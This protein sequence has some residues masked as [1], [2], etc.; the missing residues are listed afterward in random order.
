M[1]VCSSLMV[2]LLLVTGVSAQ[3]SAKDWYAAGQ[4]AVADAKRV[5]PVGDRAK[6]VILFVGDG[7]GVTTVTAARIF[8]G[9]RRG[10]SGEENL[11]SFE[12]FPYS[13]LVKT[14]TVDMQTPD[15]AGTMT[16]MATG[17]KS[18][19]WMLSLDP[20]VSFGDVRAARGGELTTIL[21]LCERAGLATGIVTTT[22]VTHATPA[23]LYAHSPDRTWESD[24]WLSEGA[25]AAGFP[26]IARQLI[27][28]A[29]GDGIDVVFGGGRVAFLPETIVD[30]EYPGFRGSR[31]DGRNLIET[32]MKKAGT[33]Y[34]TDRKGFLAID[35]SKAGRVL[36]LFEP[37][38][39]QFDFDRRAG[40][41]GEPSL[42]EMTG[43]AIDL[44]S[45][46][47]GSGSVG[48]GGGWGNGRGR[49]RGFFLM[50]EAGRIDH[51]HH[52]NN[53][54]R[55]LDDTVALSDAVK[56]A[57]EKTNRRETLILVTADHGHVFTMAGYPGRGNDITGIVKAE[58]EKASPYWAMMN[59]DR[60]GLRYTTLG[61]MNGPGA[62][63][64]LPRDVLD[65]EATCGPD[66]RQESL[67]G[68]ISETHGGQDVA[69]YAD[70]P[71]A[72]LFRGVI[73][74]NV[75]F[76]V[77][78]DALGLADRARGPGTSSD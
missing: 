14:Y 63:G 61:Y 77:M 1:R 59:Q 7:M 75:I 15:S 19:G 38:H 21:D 35:A 53:A 56:V 69:I 74:Q 47:R 58:G 52:I 8:E 70:G 64:K 31:K 48:G 44:L 73:E 57:V 23:A 68:M 72:H 33:T 67:V 43:K 10:E 20:K 60:K 25:K 66:Y 12:K 28:Y 6:N 22:R 2:A 5:Q 49:G 51:A 41:E 50:V 36:G 45:R 34:V 13:A 26:D 42:A 78:V 29:E 17:V 24:A 16:A 27:D 4:K 65:H 32:W 46:D 54:F 62:R 3:E 18:R 11:L 76:H 71:G 40:G 30:V 55:A 37:S 39:M 9:Q